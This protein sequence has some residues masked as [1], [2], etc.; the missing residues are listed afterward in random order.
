M[1][2]T[3][4]YFKGCPNSAETLKHLEQLAFEQ[5]IKTDELEEIE[6]PDLD[7]AEKSLFQGSPTILIDGIDIYTNQ[8][9]TGFNYSCR[10]YDFDGKRTGIIPKEYIEMKLRE[11]RD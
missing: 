7:S 5:K 4:Q 10:V 2:V 11:L 3:F 9:P 1:K 6:V 8:K